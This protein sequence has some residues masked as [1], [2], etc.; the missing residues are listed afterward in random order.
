MRQSQAMNSPQAYPTELPKVML[1]QPAVQH[2]RLPVFDIVRELGKETYSLTVFGPTDGGM[3]FGGGERNYVVDRPLCKYR[4]FGINYE[5]FPWLASEIKSS[6]P[7]VVIMTL[8]PR[9]LESYTIKNQCVKT[10]TVL[11]GWSKIHSYGSAPPFV[12]NALK[13]FL[14]RRFDRVICYGRSAAEE[15]A[16]FGF[17]KDRTFI[18]QNTID[19]KSVS[20]GKLQMRQ[21]GEELRNKLGLSSCPTVLCIGRF[22]PEK[23]QTDLIH[24]WPKVIKAVP[25]ARLL[26]VG[27]GPNLPEVEEAA[28]SSCAAESIIF[29]G[30]AAFG[31][32]Y[33]WISTA[34]VNV[35]CGAVGLA[36][37]QSMA[38]GTPTL[39]ADEAGVDAEL[40]IHGETGWRYQ[41]GC[42]ASL[43]R[44]LIELL[45]SSESKR[46]VV[47]CAQRLLTNE[48]TIENMAMQIHRCIESALVR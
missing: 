29:A 5:S 44:S 14:F 7:S 12:Q 17:P 36:I 2:Y 22:E 48:V 15:L 40:V 20:T 28:K 42:T 39:I 31:D 24:A 38:L 10:G 30:R 19:T 35:Q 3:A 41:K 34:E 32:D 46:Q 37:N 1:V 18:A 21:R 9:C 25:D 45:N 47:E 13:R 43:A 4:R 27:S 33:A 26:F 8:N 6:N 11:V 23:R 16:G